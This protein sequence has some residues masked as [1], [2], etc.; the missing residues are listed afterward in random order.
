MT[1]EQEDRKPMTLE[2]LHQQLGYLLLE[3]FEPNLKVMYGDF[4]YGL[5]RARTP[6]IHKAD[7]YCGLDLGEGEEFLLL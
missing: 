3:G 7:A 4:T 2:A 6:M 5:C 1:I